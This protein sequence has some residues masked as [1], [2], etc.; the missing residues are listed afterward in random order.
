[1][2][3]LQIGRMSIKKTAYVGTFQIAI[4]TIM[5]SPRALNV[6][7]KFDLS[8]RVGWNSFLPRNVG[9]WIYSGPVA[10]RFQSVF[11]LYYT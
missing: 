7:E 9:P 10:L 6:G 3:R 2:L 4:I 1:M 8:T 5:S 11:I